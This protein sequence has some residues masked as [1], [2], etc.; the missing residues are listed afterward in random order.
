ME[1]FEFYNPVHIIFGVGQ[2]SRVGQ[3]AELLGKKALIVTYKEHD[4]FNELLDEVEKSL[5]ACEVEM[6]PFFGVTA[7]PKM[8]EVSQGI[9]VSKTN[10]VDLVIGLGG[11]SAMDTAKLIAAGIFYHGDLWDMVFSRHDNTREV[12][13]PQK[14]LPLL[15]I[16]TLPATGSEM[17]PTAVIT[18]EKTQEKSYT[19]NQ[20]LYPK[21]SIV[22]PSLTCSLPQF[23]TA[24]AG[25]DT[26]SHVLEFYLTGYEDAPLNNRIQEGVILTVMEELP[27]VLQDQNN[28]SARSNL[29]WSS[30]VALNGW[31]QPGDGWTPMHQLGHVLSARHNITHGASLSIIMPAW[32]KRFYKTR[33]DRYVQFGE[34]VFNVDHK[35]KTQEKVALE[36]MEL[37]EAFLEK[38]N[39][40]TRL[41]QVGINEEEIDSFTEDVVRVSFGSNGMLRSRPPV[42][43]QG[44]EEVYLLA[45]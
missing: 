36:G 38:I 5:S 37:F 20:C 25:A 45:L 16:P 13:P 24:C 17:N 26:I 33:L 30:I 8:S 39:V 18:N 23:Q 10:E 21:V 34:R 12:V 19:W 2:V 40:P 3:E 14:A 41:S 31:S 32:M 4:F 1:K 15:M 7:N 28:L 42:T 6:V 43:R 9:D 29:Q 35:N 11:G 27:K 44:V 22:D